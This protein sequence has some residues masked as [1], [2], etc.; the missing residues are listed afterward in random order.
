MSCVFVRCV[1]GSVRL[2]KAIHRLTQSHMQGKSV[3]EVDLTSEMVRERPMHDHIRRLFVSRSPKIA[4]QLPFRSGTLA[5][6]SF[7]P[8]SQGR[9]W[10]R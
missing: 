1:P 5:W 9:R 10:A 8:C 2:Q 3:V 6:S 4:T 7:V